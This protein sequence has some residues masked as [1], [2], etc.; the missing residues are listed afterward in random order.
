MEV[1]IADY[2]KKKM[3]KE[4]P[5]SN[6][7]P[8]L[9]AK[10]DAGK[11]DE[12]H[13]LLNKDNVIRIHYGK[14]ARENTAKFAHRFIGSRFVLTRKAIDDETQID[15]NDLSTFVVKGRWCLQG[16]LDPDLDVK[17]E[18]G[19]LKPPTL[20]QMG[21]MTLLQLF[22]SLGWIMQSGDIKGAF[23]EAGPLEDC[24]RPLYA[25]HP[26]GGIPGLD[27]QAVIEIVGNLYGQND[28]PAAWFQTFDRELKA[29]GWT[30]CA[31]DACLHHVRDESSQL[32]G[33]LGCHVDDCIVG[34]A[35]PQFDASIQ[36]LRKRFPF[37]KWRVGSGE[38]CG[39]FYK[40]ETDGTTHMSMKKC[41]ESS[42]CFNPQRCFLKKMFGTSSSE[43]TPCDQR[44]SQLAFFSS[45]TRFSCPDQ[46]ES[47][48]FSKSKG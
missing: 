3:Q 30:P 38:F 6:N 33:L 2:L 27:S 9:Q 39:A 47:T 48:E 43:G 41:T 37:R 36:A 18:E 22:S 44:Q 34:G 40:Q 17:A 15:P 14:K 32:I 20:S 24:F 25:H 1:L 10:V 31:F 16:H 7:S 42:S 4:L 29:L 12:W 8:S 28:A 46:P 26:P 11:K 35:G 5:H 13:T 45:Q 19:R 21:R 23:L